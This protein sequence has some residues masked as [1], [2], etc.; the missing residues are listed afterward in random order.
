MLTTGGTG[1]SPRDVTPEATA[2]VLERRADGLIQAVH[3]AMLPKLPACVLSRGIA[4][5]L[6]HALV[7]NCPG[8]PKAVR[9]TVE[10]L[11][12]VLPHALEQLRGSKEGH[13]AH[14]DPRREKVPGSS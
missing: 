4:G 1:F 14:E 6:G 7:I 8:K 9:E 10:I 5:T 12:R 2:A 13:G 3:H 11:A